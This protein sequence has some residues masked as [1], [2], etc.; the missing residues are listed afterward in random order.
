MLVQ[1]KQQAVH[2]NSIGIAWNDLFSLY[3]NSSHALMSF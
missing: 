2:H 3:L 1:H